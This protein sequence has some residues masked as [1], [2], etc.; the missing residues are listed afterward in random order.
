M[1]EYKENYYVHITPGLY[2]I[3]YKFV[4]STCPI[5]CLQLKCA[6][7]SPQIAGLIPEYGIW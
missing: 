4:Y 7:E 3:L 5:M 6:P 2:Y 1:Q